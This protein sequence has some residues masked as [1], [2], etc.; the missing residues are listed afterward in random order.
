MRAVTFRGVESVRVDD[1][2]EPAL[3]D[4]RDAIVAVEVAGVC[5]SDLHVYHGREVGL[6]VGTVL[7]HELAGRVIALGDGV[8][9]LSVGDRVVSPFSTS[10]GAC[11]YCLRGHTCRCERGQLRGWVEGGRGLHGAQAERVRVPLADA[12]LV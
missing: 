11:F 8:T 4:A 1:V 6:D 7:G 10:C 2:P 3:L 5:G 9:G 12:T